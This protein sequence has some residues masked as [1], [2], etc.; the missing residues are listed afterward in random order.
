MGH[1]PVIHEV[2]AYSFIPILALQEGCQR[3]EDVS[4]KAEG[5]H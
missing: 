1:H 3:R 2:S 4:N 5:K